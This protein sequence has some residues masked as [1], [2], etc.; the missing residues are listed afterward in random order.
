MKTDF[1]H[2]MSIEVLEHRPVAALDIDGRRVPVSGGGIVLTGV[3]ADRD[4]PSIRRNISPTEGR[5]SDRRTRDALAVAAA[6]PEPLLDR[7]DRLWWGPHGLDARPA[8]RPAADLRH[9]RGR[10]RQVGGRR[11]RAG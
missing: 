5:V 8:R 2:K 11:S 1:P 3:R 6:A 10:G 9:V 4:L 7:G